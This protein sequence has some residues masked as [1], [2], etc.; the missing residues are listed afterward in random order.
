MRP[1]EVP[2]VSTRKL[3]RVCLIDRVDLSAVW[4]S[5]TLLYEQ[6]RTN[7]R[8]EFEE[9]DTVACSQDKDRRTSV[10]HISSRDLLATRLANGPLAVRLRR[11]VSQNGKDGAYTD[12]RVEVGTSVEWVEEHAVLSTIDSAP[13]DGWMLR[14]FGRKHCDR[15]ARPKAAHQ[16]L[17]RE[18]IEGLLFLA[19]HIRGA[20]VAEHSLKPRSS[21]MIRNGLGREGNR[22]NDP[23]EIAARALMLGL[24]HEN[25]A[26]QTHQVFSHCGHCSS[27]EVQ[28]GSSGRGYDCRPSDSTC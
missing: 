14:L 11:D 22:R 1:R 16:N 27:I 25:M 5:N 4:N 6:E 24:F 2:L 20:R 10:E 26:L 9:V 15:C 18:N 3:R 8:I 21:N 19:L 12:T 7:V 28:M 17:V 13:Q 23:G